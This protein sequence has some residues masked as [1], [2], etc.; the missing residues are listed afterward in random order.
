MS[1]LIKS[2]SIVCIDIA[3]PSANIMTEIAI[4]AQE[5]TSDALIWMGPNPSSLASITVDDHGYSVF[6]IHFVGSCNRFY[7]R[8]GDN[9]ALYRWLDGGSAIKTIRTDT[10]DLLSYF[11]TV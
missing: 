1:E 4:M 5:K 10:N 11:P 6:G 7:Y 9:T 8:D 3:N 2:S